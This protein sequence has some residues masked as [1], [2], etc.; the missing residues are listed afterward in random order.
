MDRPTIYNI[1]GISIGDRIKWNEKN[2]LS[3]IIVSF[4]FLKRFNSCVGI[5]MNMAKTIAVSRAS[6]D[7]KLSL[8]S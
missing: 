8:K 4:V 5:S 6:T 2:L 1:T 7:E 3:F